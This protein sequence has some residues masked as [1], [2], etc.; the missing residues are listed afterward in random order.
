LFDRLWPALEAALQVI[1]AE[2]TT[3][4]SPE[5]LGDGLLREI[6][7]LKTE[8]VSQ[9][10]NIRQLLAL[11][12]SRPEARLGWALKSLEGVWF[13][14]LTQTTYCVRVR[15]GQF[16]AV[17]SY[18]GVWGA[19]GQYRGKVVGEAV[20]GRFHW[21]DGR[22]DGF[23]YLRPTGPA[24]LEGGW[25]MDYDVPPETARNLGLV[26]ESLPGMVHYQWQRTGTVDDFP[27]W[28]N[29]HFERKPRQKPD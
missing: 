4:I 28:S 12:T 17:Y 5:I 16:S 25:W 21:F 26:G 11:L 15:G 20:V 9:R 18:G 2:K 1:P 10:D 29:A 7:D 24:R 22:N 3:E 6:G 23:F 19:T 8:L 27:D 13:N 14:E